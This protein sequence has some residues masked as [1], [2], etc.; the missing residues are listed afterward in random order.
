MIGTRDRRRESQPLPP[1]SAGHRIRREKEGG[2]KWKAQAITE[3]RIKILDLVWQ[4]GRGLLQYDQSESKSRV[5]SGL[6][7]ISRVP[8]ASLQHAG[9][10]K[11]ASFDFPPGNPIL[12]LTFDRGTAAGL[13]MSSIFISKP[14]VARR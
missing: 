5:Q 10:V 6:H 2:G 9:D 3:F 4:S 11:S 14:G 7:H 8:L 13:L 12:E 1:S